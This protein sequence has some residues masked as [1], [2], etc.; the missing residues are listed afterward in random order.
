MFNM[1]VKVI[2][3]DVFLSPQ[4]RL[5]SYSVLLQ[6][7]TDGA[8]THRAADPV[9]CSLLQL[10]MSRARS[11]QNSFSCWEKITTV[12]S[13]IIRICPFIVNVAVCDGNFTVTAVRNVLVVKMW[14]TRCLTFVKFNKVLL[15]NMELLYLTGNNN[16]LHLCSNERNVIHHKHDL[17]AV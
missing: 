8:Q 6:T 9:E 5:F 11:K 4:V 7:P 10:W 17:K 2:P 13:G 15:K 1:L 12:F 14:C 3:Q 16:E